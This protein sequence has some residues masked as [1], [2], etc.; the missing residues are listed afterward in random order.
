[1]FRHN[2]IIYNFQGAKRCPM[3]S[4]GVYKKK[5]NSLVP[6]SVPVS[7]PVPVPEKAKKHCDFKS[8]IGHGHGHAHGHEKISFYFS[9]YTGA[10][11]IYFF[12]IH[13]H[14]I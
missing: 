8:I 3:P 10:G 12:L 2:K 13:A 5:T 4:P 9:T 11:K 7:V 1:M 14:V 6:V